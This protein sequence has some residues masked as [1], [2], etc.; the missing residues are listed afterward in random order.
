M[1]QAFT[2]RD[3]LFRACDKP[4]GWLEEQH[5]YYSLSHYA[6]GKQVAGHLL[7]KGRDPACWRS[8]RLHVVYW[9]RRHHTTSTPFYP[10]RQQRQPITAGPAAY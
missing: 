9:S 4:G 5:P 2:F 10:G 7:L 6:H 1:D 8:I 3:V